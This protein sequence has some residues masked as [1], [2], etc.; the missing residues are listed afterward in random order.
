MYRKITNIGMENNKKI[1]DLAQRANVLVR[2][3]FDGQPIVIYDDHRWILNVLFKVFKEKTMPKPNLIYF[4][5]HDDAEKSEGRSKLL[6]KI[7]VNSLEEATE[8]QF[9]AFVDYDCQTNDGG[10]LTTAL[11]LDLIQDVVNIGG[12]HSHN[13]TNFN[14]IYNSE[15]KVSHNVFTIKEDLEYALGSRGS[16]GDTCT[17]QENEKLR[18]FFGIN[19]HYQ[20]AVEIQSPYILDFD[21]DFF[22][23]SCDDFSPHGWT[24]KIVDRKFPCNGFQTTCMKSLIREASLITICREPDFCG[25]IGDS[26]RILNLIDLYFFD[27][28][29]GTEVTI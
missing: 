14:G 15:D 4:D 6:N 11:E 25:S 17:G 27:G 12:R 3:T 9:G 7:G 18:L 2:E 23:M 20:G 13:I 26:N 21:L 29:I 22:T 24:Q 16:L 19:S 8:K 10:W 1:I 5:A 28:R